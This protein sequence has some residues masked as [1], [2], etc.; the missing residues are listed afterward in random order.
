MS[1][2][3]DGRDRVIHHDAGIAPANGHVNPGPEADRLP[4]NGHDGNGV[5]RRNGNSHSPLTAE[6]ESLA[7]PESWLRTTREGGA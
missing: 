4:T 3:R 6:S 1:A 7:S 5:R 2:K